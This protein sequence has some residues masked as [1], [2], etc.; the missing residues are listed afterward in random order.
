MRSR[1]LRTFL[2]CILAVGMTP[3]AGFAEELQAAGGS[4]GT[5]AQEQAHVIDEVE[6]SQENPVVN[7]DDE[8]DKAEPA[9]LHEDEQSQA[10]DTT[11]LDEGQSE[12]QD[13]SE[14]EL[15][16]DQK[17]A[18]TPVVD[19]AF[20]EQESTLVD[21]QE[22]EQEP[23]Q[24]QSSDAENQNTTEEPILEEQASFK[25]IRFAYNE[26]LIQK[27]GKQNPSGRACYEYAFAYADTILDGKY[28]SWTE[29]DANGGKLG[30]LQAKGGSS[31]WPRY[32]F[33]TAKTNA[34]Q[35]KIAYDAVNSGHVPLIFVTLKNGIHRW[36]TVVGYH[37]VTDPSKLTL[38][39]FDVLD[40]VAGKVVVA[41]RDGATQRLKN[42]S[43]VFETNVIVSKATGTL[44]PQFQNNPV[45]VVSYAY[46]GSGT[47]TVKGW[48]YDP[49]V[50]S[51]SIDVHVYVGGKAGEKGTESHIVKANQT[52]TDTNKVYGVS[53][54]H[55][56]E[57]TF[58]TAKRGN[59]DVYFYAINVGKGDGNT[60]DYG[61][62]PYIGYKSYDIANATL[63]SVAD[64]MVRGSAIKPKLTVKMEGTTLKEGSDYSLSYKNNVKVGTATITVSGRGMFWGSKNKTFKIVKLIKVSMYRLYNPNSGEHFYT[65][66]AGE[67]DVLTK[68]GWRYE[69]IGWTAPQ[70]S[71]APVYR[72]YNPNAGDHHYT[73]SAGERDMLKKV[74]WKDEGIGWYS[75][76]S[77]GVPLYRQ[78]NPNARTGTH[79]Y[80]T[81]KAENDHLV[82]LGWKAEGIGW[83]GLK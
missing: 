44:R 22:P 29:Y 47:L 83:Y 61:Y 50:P 78:Y 53:G 70:W 30:E 37:G 33:Q 54:K 43:G 66:S 60:M 42:N 39:N 77:K 67:R 65:A 9:T 80:T 25:A 21:E 75:D 81:N 28:H 41:N 56:F 79:N 35:L 69:G 7:L 19:S 18:D 17:T 8:T 51:Q 36:M 58:N 31:M 20:V 24:E 15:P 52:S 46:G 34:E 74:G 73:T 63:S 12:L 14:P 23:E 71:K 26:S 38:A 11:Q 16:E 5:T 82:K 32:N 76:T 59:T 64:Q 57:A 45:L 4:V 27:T 68:A 10:A 3:V 6:L 1:I 72:L 48:A 2:S 49:D 55:G 13:S 62:N 40:P